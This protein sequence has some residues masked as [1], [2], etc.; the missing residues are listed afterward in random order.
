MMTGSVWLTKLII[1]HLLTDFAEHR[2]RHRH[3]P[4]G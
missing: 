2:D 4:A 3:W 1:A